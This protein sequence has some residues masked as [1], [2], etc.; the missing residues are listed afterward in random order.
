MKAPWSRA[1][2]MVVLHG[3]EAKQPNDSRS[4]CV[5]QQHGWHDDDDNGALEGRSILSRCGG[6][7][8]RHKQPGAFCAIAS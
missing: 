1:Q 4:G 6:Q 2:T 8:S 3:F 5:S 7:E